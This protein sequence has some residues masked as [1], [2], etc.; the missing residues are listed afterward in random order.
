MMTLLANRLSYVF[1]FEG[2]SLAIDTACSSSLVAIHLACDSLARGESRLAVA[3][4]VNA[5]LGPAF[6]IAESRAGMLSPTGRSRTFDARADGYVRGEGAGIVVLKRLA[7]ALADGDHIYSVIRASAVN[8]D[9]HSEGLTVP[10]GDAQQK[11]MREACARAG[12][13]PA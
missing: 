4:G 9:G 13:A 3:G 5:L 10:S 2:P 11:L 6:T 1:G 8:Q 12:I 7:E